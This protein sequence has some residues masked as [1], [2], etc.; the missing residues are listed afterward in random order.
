MCISNS[1]SGEIMTKELYKIVGIYGDKKVTLRTVSSVVE[2]KAIQ[3]E[4]RKGFTSSWR[5]EIEQSTEGL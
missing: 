3:K 1:E 4:F 2:A 5:I